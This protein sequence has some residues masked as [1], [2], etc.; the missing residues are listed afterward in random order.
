DQRGDDH[1]QDDAGKD[2][3]P[4]AAVDLGGFVHIPGD[5]A[6]E[7]HDQEDVEAA[8]KE[9]GD[10]HRGVGAHPAHGV[11]QHEPGDHHDLAG[12]HHGDDHE[13]EPEVAALE[14]HPGQAEGHHRRGEDH[15][16]GGEDRHKEGVGEEVAEAVA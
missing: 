4:A 3:V 12:Q 16:H 10:D 14:L 5:A 11:I 2:A 6:D 8:G 1:R 13:H 9:V 15:A 7:L